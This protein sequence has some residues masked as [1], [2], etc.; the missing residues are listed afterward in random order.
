MLLTQVQIF[1][2][3]I[4]NYLDKHKG[5]TL[6]P[7]GKFNLAGMGHVQAL[8]KFYKAGAKIAGPQAN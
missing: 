7:E 2:K 1:S 3:R 4:V 5:R 8:W 6:S